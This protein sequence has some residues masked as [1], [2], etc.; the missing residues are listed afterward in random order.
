MSTATPN[1]VLT[2]AEAAAYLGLKPHTLSVWRTTKHVKI[3]YVKIG[4]AVRY[5]LADLEKFI[6][7]NTV[8]S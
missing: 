3:P 2:T 7:K 1:A 5:R 8:N 4:G 6:E